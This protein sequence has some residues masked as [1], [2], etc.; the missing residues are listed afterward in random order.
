MDDM[1]EDDVIQIQCGTTHCAYTIAV[2]E[3][4]I[5]HEKII[6]CPMCGWEGPNDFY[7][8]P[9]ELEVVSQEEFDK[10]LEEGSLH[11]PKALQE[12]ARKIIKQLYDEGLTNEDIAVETS[13]TRSMI[14]QIE[15]GKFWWNKHPDKGKEFLE[16][17]NKVSGLA[18]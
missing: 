12:Q 11:T 10:V 2:H 15:A 16:K 6:Q 18:E 9:V 4:S 13:C 17:L 1:E 3:S 5:I 7:L 8:E 14:W